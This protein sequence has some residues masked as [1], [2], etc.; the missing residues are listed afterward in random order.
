MSDD[1]TIEGASEIAAILEEVWERPVKKDQVWSYASRA[2]T[3]LPVRR[4]MGRMYIRES[5]LR[6]WAMAMMEE[7]PKRALFVV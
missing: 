6:A 2:A 7:R 4:A 3:L 1:R 5:H